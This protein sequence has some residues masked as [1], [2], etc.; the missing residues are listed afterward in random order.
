[1]CSVNRYWRTSFRS[2]IA[3]SN[4]LRV[5]SAYFLYLLV[6]QYIDLFTWIARDFSVIYSFLVCPRSRDL[7]R[8][9]N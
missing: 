1:M 4:A 2:S 9:M 6:F 8:K 3:L 7:I 5:S